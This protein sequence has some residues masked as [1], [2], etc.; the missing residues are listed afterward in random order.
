MG[1]PGAANRIRFW[2]PSGL[3]RIPRYPK[4]MSQTWIRRDDYKLYCKPPKFQLCFLS[5]IKKKHDVEPVIKKNTTH[6]LEPPISTKHTHGIHG[7]GI[8]AYIYQN[9]CIGYLKK[10]YMLYGIF[11]RFGWISMPM[12]PMTRCYVS[13]RGQQGGTEL[14][15][16]GTRRRKRRLGPCGEWHF[17]LK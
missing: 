12:L 15:L 4:I 13:T 17:F 2:P 8:L 14:R 3:L 11:N 16:R 9:K 1:L 10:Q 5:S 7:R 6:T